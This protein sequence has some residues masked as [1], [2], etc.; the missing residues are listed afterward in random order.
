MAENE[1]GQ[2]KSQE[3]TE[4]RLSEARKKGQVPR[5]QELNT[6]ILLVTSGVFFVVFGHHLGLGISENFANSL[7]LERELLYDPRIIPPHFIQLLIDTLITLAPLYAILVI[8][9][10]VGPTSVGGANFA[11]EALRPKFDK[12][13]IIKGLK[14]NFGVTGLMNLG[15]AFGKVIVVGPVAYFVVA[16]FMP[17][18][19]DLGK[20]NVVA[21]IL[22]TATLIAWA[23]LLIASSLLLI[24]LIDVPYQLWNHKRQLKM[25]LQEVKDEHKQTDVKPEVKR[26][27]RQMQMEMM[28]HRMMAEVPKADVVITNPTHYA[29][30][31]IYNSSAMIAPRLIAKG[32]DHIALEIRERAEEHGVIRVEA[33][34][35]ARAIYYTTELD[36]EIPAALFVA[37]ARI[38]AYV[39][40]LRRHDAESVTMP[41]DLPVPD[42]LLDPRRARQARRAG[43]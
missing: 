36:Q 6:V 7:T 40:Q 14:K 43:I 18:L 4:K 24:A 39:Y 33:P 32:A 20:E 21:A 28:Q 38:L 10:I 42:E 19:L 31:L 41:D 16:G 23:F 37:V 2:E 30:A 27:M 29:V 15:K 25:T 26:R 17:R 8:A 5:S 3:P 13:N 9:A 34:R 35:V 1:N 22:H 12:L 11:T